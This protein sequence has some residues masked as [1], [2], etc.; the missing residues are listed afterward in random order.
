MMTKAG[1]KKATS[2][3]LI[4]A[5]GIIGSGHSAEHRVC[6]LRRGRRRVDNEAVLAGIVPEILIAISLCCA[7]WWQV[8]KEDIVSPPRLSWREFGLR[9]G[10]WRLGVGTSFH[11]RIWFEIRLLHPDRGSG[12]RR[13]L[14]AVRRHVRLSRAEGVPAL[15]RV[16]NRCD[17]TSVIMFLVAAALVSSWLI[18]V[19]EI[20]NQ[21]VDLLK[22]LMGNQTLLSRLH[23]GH[24]GDRWYRARHDA[25]HPD[26]DPISDAGHQAGRVDP[27]YFGVLFIVNNSIGLITP[28]VGVVLNVVAGVSPHSDG[29]PNPCRLALHVGRAGCAVSNGVVSPALVTVQRNGWRLKSRGYRNGAER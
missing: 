2:G 8:R 26:P 15:W 9:R 24:R 23:H 12:R 17:D 11:H 1:H 16:R 28:P 3:G 14:F 13:R 10:R 19:S 7:W 20:A 25:H 4:A 29:R 22:P 21:I 5:A 6:H 27:V 18:T